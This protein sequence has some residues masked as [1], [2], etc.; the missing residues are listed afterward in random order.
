MIEIRAQA[1]EREQWTAWLAARDHSVYHTP[2]FLT[3]LQKSSVPTHVYHA[4]QEGRLAGLALIIEDR[5]LPFPFFGAKGFCPAGLLTENEDVL[6]AL[7]LAMQ[8][9]LRRRM[10]YLEVY[11]ADTEE[12]PVYPTNWRRDHHLNYHIDLGLGMAEVR[13]RYSRAIRR[14]VKR[15]ELEQPRWR[16]V[17]TVGELRAVWRLL[18]D[19]SLRVGAPVL[20]WQLLRTVFHQLG[21]R[22]GCRCY[23]AEI[24]DGSGEWVMVNTRV[25]LVWGSRAIDWYTGGVESFSQMQIGTWLVDRILADLERAGVRVFDFGG[26]GRMGGDYGPAEFKRR[27]GGERVSICRFQ[28]RFHPWLLAIARQCYRLIWRSGNKGKREVT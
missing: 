11:E 12:T 18:R 14:N 26:A 10:L 23:V 16:L 6:Q 9:G 2:E 19:T 27:F 22:K 13:R 5:I 25:E 15:A 7:L 17:A 20:P 21:P 4:L 24:P 8:K 28:Y 1:P 3:C